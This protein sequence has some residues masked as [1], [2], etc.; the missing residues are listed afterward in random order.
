MKVKCSTEYLTHNHY[1][2][3]HCSSVK[4]LP[5]VQRTQVQS[6]GWEGPLE[7]R[8]AAH[9]R[10]LALRILMVRGA[11][12]AIV[13]AVTYRVSP[14]GRRDWANKHTHLQASLL[15][16]IF[17]TVILECSPN[18][19]VSHFGNY[20]IFQSSLFYLLC[21]LWSV[22]FDETIVI[23]LGCPSNVVNLINVYI[24]T[25]FIS[26]SPLFLSEGL[27]ILW[28]K[29]IVKLSQLITLQWLLS[30]PVKGRVN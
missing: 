24:L 20:R 26:Y 17:P 13:Y 25:V 23:V 19:S 29:T 28:D 8:M 12:W 9:S 21:D 11:W 2:G 4:N 1:D 3:F 15:D 14:W 30:V 18:V 27:P 10:I 22:I 16:A 5:A 7:K 6:L